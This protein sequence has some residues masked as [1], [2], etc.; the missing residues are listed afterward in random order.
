MFRIVRSSYVRTIEAKAREYDE[1]ERR[2]QLT[3]ERLASRVEDLN[4]SSLRELHLRRRLDAYVE[5][6]R[7]M[8]AA[9]AALPTNLEE[10]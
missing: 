7:L 4:E 9:A 3:S 8:R 5:A 1:L 2:H 10:T 6:E